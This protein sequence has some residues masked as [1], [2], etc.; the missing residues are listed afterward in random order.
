MRVAGRAGAAARTSLVARLADRRICRAKKRTTSK[1]RFCGRSQKFTPTIRAFQ[2][3]VRRCDET[4]RSGDSAMGLA[5]RSALAAH[6]RTFAAAIC[7]S[8]RR[9]CCCRRTFRSICACGW[10]QQSSRCCLAK[11]AALMK[12]LKETRG[13]IARHADWQQICEEVCN[14]AVNDKV[15]EAPPERR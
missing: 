14:N 11:P 15:G 7:R 2:R 3:F 10:L 13:A 6:A 12:R 1:R 4:A 8:R 9:P 5:G